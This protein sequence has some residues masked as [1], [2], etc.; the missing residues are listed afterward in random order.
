MAILKRYHPSGLYR[1]VFFL[2]FVQENIL[3]SMAEQAL[4]TDFGLSSIAAT[5]QVMCGSP[6]GGSY[7]WMAPELLIGEGQAKSS[8]DIWSFASLYY[9]VRF[10]VFPSDY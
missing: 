7:R 10:F 8:C 1:V 5:S 3:V 9:E 2:T 6:I 4:I